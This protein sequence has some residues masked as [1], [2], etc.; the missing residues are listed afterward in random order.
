MTHTT[1]NKGTCLICG[2]ETQPEMKCTCKFRNTQHTTHNDEAIVDEFSTEWHRLGI[3]NAVLAHMQHWLR[4][5]LTQAR[6][7]AR[8]DQDRISRE[9]ER[10]AV[11]NEAIQVSEECERGQHTEFDEWRAFKCFRN[12]LRSRLTTQ[13]NNTV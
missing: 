3:P 5:A 8:A 13:N 6:A 2:K 9:E 1:H 4:Q 12:T 11:L 7:Q 10:V